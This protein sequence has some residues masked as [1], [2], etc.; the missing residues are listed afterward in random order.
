MIVQQFVRGTRLQLQSEFESRPVL[1]LGTLPVTISDVFP[2]PGCVTEMMTVLTIVMN[3]RT[4][5]SPLVVRRSGNV[6]LE[7]AFLNLSSVILT[8]TVETFQMRPGAPM[9]HVR[10]HSSNVAMADVFHSHGSVTERMIVETPLMKETAVGSRHVNI[11][12]SRVRVVARVS[13]SHGDVMET[14]T[15]L[16]TLTRVDV[17][18]SHAP[19]PSSNVVI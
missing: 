1:I 17:P 2:R 7:G 10:H 14:T 11:S 18:P 19:R 12:S 4:A 9:L 8:M 13:L 16:T 6:L 15:V 5:L 3:F